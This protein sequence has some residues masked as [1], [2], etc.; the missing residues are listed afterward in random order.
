[1][2]VEKENI[3]MIQKRKDRKLK[4]TYQYKNKS[5]IQCSKEKYP[6]NQASKIT[7]LRAK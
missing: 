2:L 6:N 1:M 5:I 4:K 3:K 7:W